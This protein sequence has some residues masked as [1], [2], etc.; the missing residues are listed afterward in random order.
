MTGRNTT[1]RLPD[2][3]PGFYKGLGNYPGIGRGVAA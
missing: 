3:R 1:S 2:A